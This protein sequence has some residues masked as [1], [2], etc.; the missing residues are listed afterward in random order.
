MKN[1]EDLSPKVFTEIPDL[2]VEPERAEKDEEMM[3]RQVLELAPDLVDIAERAMIERPDF[4][5]CMDKSA[6]IFG[7]PLC[8]FISNVLQADKKREEEYNPHLTFLNNNYLRDNI[9]SEDQAGNMVV[10]VAPSIKNGIP[11][12]F[13][14]LRGRKFFVVDE[15]LSGGKS[16]RSLL[17]L[18][19]LFNDAQKEEGH[20]I[21]VHFFFFK[22]RPRPIWRRRDSFAKKLS[23][24]FR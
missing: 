18:I 16:L 13:S 6:R 10:D 15:T 5:V 20:K 19:K 24:I 3:D 11:E 12:G 1:F 2:G 23:A 17:E 4:V 22:Q 8:R 7:V 9:I 14:S 21:D